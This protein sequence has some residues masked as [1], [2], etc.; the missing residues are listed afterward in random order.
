MYHFRDMSMYLIF[1]NKNTFFHCSSGISCLTAWVLLEKKTKTIFFI[2]K[3]INKSN[4]IYQ[5]NCTVIFRK[6][7]IRSKNRVSDQ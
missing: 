4:R 7:I 5:V 3:K 2:S 6:N 1:E